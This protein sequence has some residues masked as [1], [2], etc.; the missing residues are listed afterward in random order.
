M[1]DTVDQVLDSVTAAETSEVVVIESEE[2]EEVSSEPVVSTEE[3][4]ENVKEIL[5]NNNTISCNNCNC[6][7]RLDKLIELLKST[8]SQYEIDDDEFVWSYDMLKIREV[9]NEL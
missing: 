3:V 4:V 6:E 7:E 9:L 8:F 2:V 5:N 1:S